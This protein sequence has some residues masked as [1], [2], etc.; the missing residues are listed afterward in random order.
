[1]VTKNMILRTGVADS[2]AVRKLNMWLHFL[3]YLPALPA[4]VRSFGADTHAALLA[5]Q[6]A[7]ALTA[8]GVMGA[9]TFAA[10]RDAVYKRQQAGVLNTWGAMYCS[11]DDM[12]KLQTGG[13]QVI[14]CPATPKA[15][16]LK[17]FPLRTDAAFWYLQL[18]HEAQRVQIAV[19]SAGGI[20][21]LSAAVT[22]GRIA[23]SMH[24]PALAFDLHTGAGMN[25][26]EIDE[27][28]MELEGDGSSRLWRVWARSTA[29]D[30]TEGVQLRTIHNPYTYTQRTG[31]GKPVTGYFV[32]FTALCERFHFRRIPA[33][34]SFFDT[35]QQAGRVM[36]GAEWWHFQN[37]FCLFEGW[38]TFFGELGRIYTQERLAKTSSTLRK[39]SEATYG[40]DWT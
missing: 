27:F 9:R 30:S 21:G 13:Q 2:A 24:Y 32:D 3:G 37:D 38:S 36:M 23:T 25:K 16:G 6:R 34:R 18:W 20:R 22:A 17:V 31:T 4:A 28:V 19:P 15:K 5:F 14:D 10:L 8:D 12:L 7:Y 40:I 29:T 1:M 11:I 33:R 35:T 39:G 26:P